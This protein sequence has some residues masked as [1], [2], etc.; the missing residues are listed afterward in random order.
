MKESRFVRTSLDDLTYKIT[1]CAMALH[2]RLGPGHREHIYQR[3]LQDQLSEA[4]MGF[5]PQKLYE[6]F[7]GPGKEKLLGYYVPDFV[8]E[9]KVIVEI[10][11]V[12]V[13]ANIHLAQVIGYLAVSGCPT[14]L[15]INFGRGS[16][17]HKRIFPPKSLQE[18]QANPRWL[19]KPDWL[20]D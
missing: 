16:L 15:L 12:Q 5:E 20:D 18:H 13:L 3:F 2:R 4:G 14:G 6:V 17:E 1:G 11:A 8:V 9:D 7:D 10:K 19:F